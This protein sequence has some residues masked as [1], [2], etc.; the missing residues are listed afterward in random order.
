M[1][2]KHSMPPCSQSRRLVGLRRSSAPLK[3]KQRPA[4]KTSS[5]KWLARRRTATR[6]AINRAGP[7]AA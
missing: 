2:F 6:A 4:L 7:A 1:Y 3:L 5:A